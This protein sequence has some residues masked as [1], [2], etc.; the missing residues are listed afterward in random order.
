MSELDSRWIF[1]GVVAAVALQRLL[2]LRRSARNER[3]LRQRGGLEAGASH[4][5][6]MVALHTGLLVSAPLEVWILERPLLPVLSSVMAVALLG[7]TVLRYWTMRTLGERWT[8]R[9]I[10]LPGTE[11]VTGGPFRWV[12]HP[13]YLAVMVETLALPMLHT[14]WLSAA[15]FTALNA[16]LLRK[17]IRVEEAAL[18]EHTNYASAFGPQTGGRAT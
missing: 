1:V 13:N 4:Y 12:R 7:A 9:V 16:V 6:W 14:A 11:A 18:R 8:T 5:P 15:V 2:E 3:D 17:R 10:Y